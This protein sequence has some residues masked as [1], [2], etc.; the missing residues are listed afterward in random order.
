MLD[1]KRY[2]CAMKTAFVF[3]TLF[4]AQVA[5]AGT[6]HTECFDPTGKFKLSSRDAELA[7]SEIEYAGQT[8][9]VKMF[10][11][12][13]EMLAW[14]NSPKSADDETRDAIGAVLIPG[15]TL[16]SN[17]ELGETGCIGTEIRIYPATLAL[18]S[19]DFASP[20]TFTCEERFMWAD[21]SPECA[22][23]KR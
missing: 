1:A 23:G 13:A 12:A 15:A 9:T 22:T 19:A 16:S 21:H 4:L 8:K 11:S 10:S 18:S 5:A 7:V 2:N 17:T 20:V 6:L 3:T 14:E